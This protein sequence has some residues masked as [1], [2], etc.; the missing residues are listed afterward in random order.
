MYFN[1]SKTTNGKK[2]YIQ[3]FLESKRIDFHCNL[4]TPQHHSQE[5]HILL[6]LTY[7]H[8][9]TKEEAPLSPIFFSWKLISATFLGLNL[10][11]M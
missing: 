7:L 1:S 8:P 5:F 6:N 2:I 11:I 3:V 9:A 10:V 4:Q